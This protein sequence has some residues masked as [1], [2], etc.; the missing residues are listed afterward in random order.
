M[1]RH[2]QLQRDK[3]AP[4]C[5]ESQLGEMLLLHT[6]LTCVQCFHLQGFYSKLP[7]HQ[8]LYKLHG[9]RWPG[10]MTIPFYR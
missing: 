3:E 2:S 9:P 5:P 8:V 6:I 10:I 4:I 7:S 1:D